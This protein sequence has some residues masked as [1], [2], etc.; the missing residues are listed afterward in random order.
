MLQGAHLLLDAITEDA[1]SREEIESILMAAAGEQT[2]ADGK[3]DRGRLLWPLRVALTGKKKS[4]GP[5][6]VAA[7]LGREETL[8]R[9]KA[10]QALL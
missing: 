5:I 2:R 9:I 4:P 8:Q 7:I 3:V 1:W 10:A 6:E